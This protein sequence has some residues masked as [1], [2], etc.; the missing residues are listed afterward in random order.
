MLATCSGAKRGASSITTRPAGTCMYSTFAGSGVRQSAGA[1]ASSS[2]FAVFGFAWS[3]GLSSAMAVAQ[4]AASARA[5]HRRGRCAAADGWAGD[6]AGS[7]AEVRR[8]CRRP[9]A[10][11]RSVLLLA[12]VVL[13]VDG[14]PGDPL[15]VF[16]RATFLLLALLDVVGLAFLLVGVAG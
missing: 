12:A 9:P 11:A 5:R 4:A 2:S 8:F 6:M 13:L 7:V 14:G 15:G 3:A 16:L 1:E 10:R